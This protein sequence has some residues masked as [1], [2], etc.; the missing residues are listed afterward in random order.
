MWFARNRRFWRQA[1]LRSTRSFLLLFLL[2]LPA[3]AQQSPGPVVEAPAWF[4]GDTWV[5]RLPRDVITWTVTDVTSDSYSVRLREA[6][7]TFNV[8]FTRTLD[9]DPKYSI[10]A[11]FVWPLKI[12]S[13]WSRPYESPNKI[14]WTLR[15]VVTGYGP[16]SVPAGAFDAFQIAIRQCAVKDPSVCEGL[17]LWYAPAVKWWVKEAWDNSPHWVANVRGQSSELINYSVTPSP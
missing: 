9:A 3:S 8:R 16:V 12:G 4:V 14:L 5:F 11:H 7:G 6:P 2:V 1:V 15:Y 13:T 17:T 10:W